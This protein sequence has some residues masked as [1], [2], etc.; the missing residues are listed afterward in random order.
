M[1][2]DNVAGLRQR[3]SLGGERKAQMAYLVSGYLYGIHSLQA[4]SRQPRSR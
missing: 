3:L 1:Q 2:F 4:Q